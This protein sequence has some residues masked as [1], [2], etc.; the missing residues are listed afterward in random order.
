[1]KINVGDIL[2]I[3]TKEGLAYILVAFDYIKAP[4]YGKLIKAYNQKFKDRPSISELSKI[5]ANDPDFWVFTGFNEQN[6]QDLEI[7]VVINIG[8]QGIT[9]DSLPSMWIFRQ[10][11]DL[12][13][14]EKMGIDLGQVPKIIEK[15]V[16]VGIPGKTESEV[17]YN[18]IESV[19]KGIS[20]FSVVNVIALKER[21]EKNYNSVDDLKLTW[22]KA[23]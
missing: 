18:N 8:D 12:S 22:D 9:Y 7:K 21:L 1:M 13:Q 11:F 16:S 6:T 23:K 15:S 20:G 2:E 10:G 3:P 5:V 14:Y 19:P 4:Q 17:K